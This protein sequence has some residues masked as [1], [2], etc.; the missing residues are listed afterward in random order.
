M[1][2]KQT[3][4]PASA[5]AAAAGR[6][7]DDRCPVSLRAADRTCFRRRSQRCRGGLGA[8]GTSGRRRCAFVDLGAFVLSL[9][10]P[11]SLPPSL[12]RSPGGSSGD[13]A[14]AGSRARA[15]PRAIESVITCFIRCRAVTE[16]FELKVGRFAFFFER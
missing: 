8:A 1:Q 2:L 4:G 15:R 3:V 16:Q 5:E 6:R 13:R 12:A 9:P 14:R 10:L 7:T 11:P